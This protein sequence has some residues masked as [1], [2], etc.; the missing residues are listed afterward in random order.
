MTVTINWQTFIGIA[1]GIAAII[2]LLGYLFKVYDFVRRQ[3]EQDKDIK[4]IKN[5]M[6][7]ITRVDQTESKSFDGKKYMDDMAKEHP[8]K[9]KKILAKYT[10][11]VKRKGY[12]TIKVKEEK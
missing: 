12:A 7:A 5:D 9:A 3:K 2:A 8:R 1:G 10:K 4:S 11:T 6:F